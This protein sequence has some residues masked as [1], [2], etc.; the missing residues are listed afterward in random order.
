[1]WMLPDC[2]PKCFLTSKGVHFT[3]FLQPNTLVDHHHEKLHNINAK[4]K[5]PTEGPC[6]AA[7]H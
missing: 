7:T 5:H 6:N 3:A 2:Q 1:M 4:V